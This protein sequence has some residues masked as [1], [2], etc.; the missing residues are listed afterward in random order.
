MLYKLKLS[1]N[2]T[3][4][5]KNICF[6]KVNSSLVTRWFKKFS[7]VCKNLNNQAKSNRFKTMDSEI[8]FQA[9]EANMCE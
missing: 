5:T 7:L 8:V 3:E 9:T 2:T 6:V 4:E 1:H